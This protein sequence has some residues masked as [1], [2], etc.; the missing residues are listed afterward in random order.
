[1][2]IKRRVM[3]LLL[4]LLC[5]MMAITGCKKKDDSS[6]KKDKTT[7]SV[8]T[9]K[10]TKTDSGTKAVDII[11][12]NRPDKTQVASQTENVTEATKTA[13]VTETKTTTAETKTTTKATASAKIDEKGTYSSKDDVALYIHTYGKLPS[14]YMTK[15]QAEAL[16]WSGG[17]LEKYAKG[18]C[19]G[20]DKFGNYEGLLPKKNGRTYTECDIDTIGASSRGAKRIIFSNDGLVYY[21]DDHYASFTLLYGNP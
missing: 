4:T 7:Q 16:G 10:T 12:A 2:K 11:N 3:L 6:S 13:S 20:G 19:I 8:A 18:K 15:K 14:N 5:L 21:T 1:M 17:S 9:V